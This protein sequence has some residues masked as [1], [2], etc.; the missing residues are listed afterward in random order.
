MA[1]SQNFARCVYFLLAK[2]AKAI[3]IWLKSF[4]TFSQ[5]GYS[6]SLLR[7]T[8]ASSRGCL[9]QEE[10][11]VCLWRGRLSRVRGRPLHQTAYGR[12]QG[13]SHD[14]VSCTQQQDMTGRDGT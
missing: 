6:V 5:N 10:C 4:F 12:R 3:W 11:A 2:L 13:E 14:Q 8:P 1:V 9:L 7:V